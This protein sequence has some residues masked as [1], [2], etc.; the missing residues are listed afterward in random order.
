[1]EGPGIFK[2]LWFQLL[3]QHR[4]A[5]K[6]DCQL[7]PNLPLACTVQN[8]VFTSDSN[9]EYTNFGKNFTRFEIYNSQM[10]FI[11]Q[12]FFIDFP[13]L[14]SIVIGDSLFSTIRPNDFNGA[15]KLLETNFFNTTI[16]TLQNNSFQACRSLQLVS[17]VNGILSTVEGNAFKGLRN[18][19]QLRLN[20]NKLT[21]LVSGILDDLVNLESFYCYYN[22]ITSIPVDFFTR[23]TKLIVVNLS[24]N[25]IVS[26]D[27]KTFINQ[28]NLNSLS[29]SNNLLTSLDVTAVTCLDLDN[30]QLTTFHIQNFIKELSISNNFLSS[31]TCDTNLSTITLDVSYNHLQNMKC[32]RAMINLTNLDIKYNK[33]AHL[34]KK[35]FQKLSK[36]WY[37]NVNGNPKKIHK[38]ISF[39]PMKSLLILRVDGLK[40][41]KVVK[42]NL[43]N[44]YKIVLTTDTWNCSRA[45][46]IAKILQNQKIMYD[47]INGAINIK[48]FKCRIPLPKLL[49]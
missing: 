29:L 6:L 22:S 20:N 32:I 8:A 44:L 2:V 15:K 48:N 41:Y 14:Q 37:L 25:Q 1:M 19:N 11:F 3:F 13:Q 49:D 24:S 5:E 23:T 10:A 26:I 40:N 7:D 30:N 31:L 38:I 36:M 39:S 28:K 9:I 16:E 33:M 47:S 27:S 35:A 21:T 17:M 12:N 46:N 4:S 42:K 45:T 43:P 34:S 18:M